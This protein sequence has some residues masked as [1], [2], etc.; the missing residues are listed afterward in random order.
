M[1]CNA[2]A[3]LLHLSQPHFLPLSQHDAN[4]PAMQVAELSVSCS[5]AAVWINDPR[6]FTNF[7][8]FS[9]HTGVFEKK[10]VLISKL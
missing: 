6:T 4:Q 1:E 8:P 7:I 2:F 5:H 10:N 3:M 9:I